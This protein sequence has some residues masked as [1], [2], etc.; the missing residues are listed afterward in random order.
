MGASRRVGLGDCMDTEIICL[1]YR[2]DD[3]WTTDKVW[4]GKAN[5]ISLWFR[6][7]SF[8][9]FTNRHEHHVRRLRAKPAHGFIE[10]GLQP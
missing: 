2:M 8:T 6:A 1:A 3:Y 4:M 9:S 10:H 5:R 7:I